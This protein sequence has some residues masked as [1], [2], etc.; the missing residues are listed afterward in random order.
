MERFTHN[1]LGNDY[2]FD[3]G[4]NHLEVTDK[5]HET[6]YNVGS[7]VEKGDLSTYYGYETV[8]ATGYRLI[9]GKVYPEVIQTMKDLE[10]MDIYALLKS[11]YTYVRMAQF[12]QRGKAVSL[13]INI[14]D[15]DQKVPGFYVNIGNNPNFVLQKD[16]TIDYAVVNGFLI[17]LKTKESNFRNAIYYGK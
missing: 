12:A 13:P 5:N 9:E 2:V 7:I 17:D 16:G 1:L 6:F 15:K 8:D 4:I 3:I 11:G 10:N 14:L